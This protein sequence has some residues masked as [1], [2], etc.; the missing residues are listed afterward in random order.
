MDEA[1]TL[2][3]LAWIIGGIVEVHSTGYR[4]IFGLTP[5][6]IIA[7]LFTSSV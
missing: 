3:L 5:H 7:P 1:R 6:L 2:S 4:P